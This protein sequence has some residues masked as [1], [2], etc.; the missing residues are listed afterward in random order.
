MARSFVA[1]VAFAAIATAAPS[2]ITPDP[3]GANKVGNG[4]GLQ[5][6]TGGCL[7]TADC[8]QAVVQSCCAFIAGGSST[9]ICSGIDV[10]NVNGKAGCGFGDGDSST[11]SSAPAAASP[12]AAAA[13]S[14]TTNSSGSSA[15]C[16]VDTSLAGSQN[17]GTGS[18]T[19]FITGQC[20]S[21]ADCASGCCVAQAS[22]PALCKAQLVTEQA[23]LTC[24]FS[25]SGSTSSAT[26]S[27]SDAAV[28][29]PATN[30]AA[31]A[32]GGSSTGSC[33]AIDTTLAGSQ[34]VGTGSGTQFITGQCFTAADCASGCCVLQSDGISL[35]KAELV[36]TQAGLTCDSSCTGGAA[37]SASSSSSSASTSP[38]SNNGSSTGSAVTGAAGSAQ[39]TVN[40]SLA[41]SQNVG[42]GSGQQFITGQC[43][44]SADCASG[45]CV[46]QAS[47]T[48]L[49]KAQLV[50][51]QAGL[52][53]D[54]T[55]A[56]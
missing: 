16:A 8:S 36:T 34:N 38:S 5:F 45:C 30:V 21:A 11:D 48:A 14:S 50:T 13:T 33:P 41:G 49:C 22:G 4:Q 51:T 39:C 10:G 52:S 27:S 9:G 24:D 37:S 28:S 19:Q 20:L 43:F 6:I 18:G 29:Q 1:L 56:A 44:S 7:S 40:T 42:K 53:C 3:N 2:P 32:S 47:G 35:C 25:C 26:S 55:C 12:P 23:G 31:T 15:Q 54:F 17:V 46:Q